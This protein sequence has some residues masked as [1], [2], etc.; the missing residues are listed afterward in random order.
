MPPHRVVTEEMVQQVKQL[1]GTGLNSDQI[2][3][4]IGMSK[5]T[6][7]KKFKQYPELKRARD[8]GRSKSVAMVV[9]RL[10]AKCMDGD[11][12]SIQ[13]F[14]RNVCPEDW[15]DLRK[16][17]IDTIQNAPLLDLSNVS[18]E[19]LLELAQAPPAEPDNDEAA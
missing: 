18:D 15:G 8:E 16:L 13:F 10:F 11:Y 2:A 12:S 1:A 3:A 6:M 7:F 5:S 17:T 4:M 19:A 9:N 14:L